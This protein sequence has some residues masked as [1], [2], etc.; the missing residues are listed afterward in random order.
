MIFDKE[1]TFPYPILASFTD[2]Y[3]DSSFLLEV[4][5]EDSD[6]EYMFKIKYEL[7]N[8]FLNDLIT[9]KKAKI[10][11]LI[12]SKDSQFYEV[13][14]NNVKIAKNRITLTKK[15][16]LQLIIMSLEEIN[17]K[18]N[19]NLH[20]FYSDVKS[21]ILV[22]KYSVLAFSNI[23]KF[24][25]DLR[26]PF[27]L[28]EK[29]LDPN[30]KSDVKIDFTSEMIVVI[31]R[32]KILQYTGFRKSHSLNNHYIYMGL[33]KALTKFLHDL[34]DKTLEVQIKSIDDPD[35]KLNYKL[36]RLMK[37]KNIEYL[38][39]DNIDEVI[40]KITDNIILKHYYAIEEEVKNGNKTS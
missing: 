35:D 40:A 10:F 18:A 2:D 38:N 8:D 34:G 14:D 9:L 31:Y 21:K 33:Q 1:A 6:D 36:Y 7:K 3:V 29:R 26:K 30:I 32:D 16:N 11:L 20:P 22:D 25:G 23:E 27:D 37:N 24:N 19:N 28:F 4:D 12:Q 15:T 39:F 17:F 5:V 13:N